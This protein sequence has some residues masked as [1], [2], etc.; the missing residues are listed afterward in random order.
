M[1]DNEEKVSNEEILKGREN[2][3]VWLKNFNDYCTIEGYFTDDTTYKTNA[4]GIKA[5]KKWIHRRLG[6]GPG[7]KHFIDS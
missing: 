7:R 1:T 5:M 2:Y 4:A 3:Y 6:N